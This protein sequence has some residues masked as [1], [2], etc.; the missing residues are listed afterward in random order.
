MG[1]KTLY[2]SLVFFSLAVVKW[3]CSYIISRCHFHYFGFSG[4]GTPRSHG[5]LF[6]IIFIY[7]SNPIPLAFPQSLIPF[8]LHQ[9]SLI[10]STEDVL[11]LSS[12]ASLRPPHPTNP[13]S[14]FLYLHLSLSG[15]L[16]THP[17]TLLTLSPHLSPP[18]PHL[19]L[20]HTPSPAS[21]LPLS[22]HLHHPHFSLSLPLTL[23]QDKLNPPPSLSTLSLSFSLP[24]PPCVPLRHV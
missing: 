3:G 2:C 19:P 15:S 24:L 6:A 4:A 16:T 9:T 13:P 8:C 14:S 21:Y 1:F 22:L 7:Y 5:S 18:P 10:S 17:S 23:C 12:L 11:I 20:S